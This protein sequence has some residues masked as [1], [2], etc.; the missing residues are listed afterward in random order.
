MLKEGNGT[1]TRE[2]G[3]V[4]NTV[5]CFPSAADDCVIVG[6]GGLL[7]ARE[8]SAFHDETLAAATKEI[9]SILAR[10]AKGNSDSNR[11]LHLLRVPSGL[12]LAWGSC[13]EEHKTEKMLGIA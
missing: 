7:E 12:F 11:H 1:T 9:N 6:V 2:W 8:V 10:V 5:V 13:I 3:I 4:K